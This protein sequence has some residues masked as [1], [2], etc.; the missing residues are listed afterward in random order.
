MA[1][2]TEVVAVRYVNVAAGVPISVPYPLY[3]AL[4]VRVVY[5]IEA[6]VA[7]YN[8]DYTIS[9]GDDFDTFTLTPT[10]ALISKI[11][12]LMLANPD[13]VNY[14]T[15]RRRL[16]YLTDAT[17]AAVRY[18]PFTAREFDR[19]ALRF[20]QIQEQL[21]RA[22]T[23]KQNFVGSVAV[24]LPAPSA[25]RSL[26]WNA[27]EDGIENGP[28]AD[29]I[30]NAQA[31]A[32]LAASYAN[33]SVQG[34]T[35]NRFGV[36]SG[37]SAVN[38]PAGVTTFS[39]PGYYADGDTGAWPEIREVVEDGSPLQPWQVR[40]N[41]GTRRWELRSD[42][43][44]PEMMGARGNDSANDTSA[45]QAAADYAALKG[46][47]F[48]LRRKSVYQINKL[49][50]SSNTKLAGS[51]TIKRR[52]AA[53]DDYTVKAADVFNVHVSGIRID[54]NLAAQTVAYNNLVFIGCSNYSAKKCDISGAKKIGGYGSGIAVVGGLND[55]DGEQ[56]LIADNK[57]SGNQ[58]SGIYVSREYNISVERNLCRDNGVDGIQFANLVYPPVS[59]VFQALNVSGNRCR[60]NDENGINFIGFYR[61]FAITGVDLGYGVPPARFVSITGNHCIDNE[62]YGLIW[63]GAGG[64]VSG[65]TIK[66]NGRADGYGGGLLCNC[67]MSVIA[68]N[69]LHDNAN[70][71][72]DA[73]GAYAIQIV[74]NNLNRGGV[75]L[76]VQTI[77]IGC[78]GTRHC[79]V[80]GNVIYQEGTHTMVGIKAIGTEATE[81]SNPINQFGIGITISN[82]RIVSNGATFSIGMHVTEGFERAK[83]ENNHVDGAPSG[84]SYF[85]EVE[86]L[87]ESN[88]TSSET[89]NS[90]GEPVAVVPSGN[91]VI[92]PDVGDTFYVSGT[93]NFDV[94][95]TVAA[96]SYHQKVRKVYMA[97]Q[98]SGY[99]YSSPPSVVFSGGGGSGAAGWAQIDTSGRIVDVVMTNLGSGYT[100]APSVSFVG[101][102]GSGA[103]AAARIG[104]NNFAG[105]KLSLM[106]Q[107]SL[108]VANTGNLGLSASHAMTGNSSLRLRGAYGN[109]YQESFRVA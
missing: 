50:L 2:S 78:G 94:I 38:V 9:L 19:T 4:D 72:I 5:G 65:N 37:L 101:G 63:Q 48:Y 104:C 71:Q 92:I 88:N 10:A 82:N 64:H 32:Q 43:V 25:G 7:V 23:L 44:T 102:S 47:L 67:E 83:I 3:E 31:Y 84:R 66:G 52:A 16:G 14:V 22:L 54:G 15:V 26:V 61:S 106:F 51:G 87:I 77:D 80:D 35:G 95:R 56:S 49:D 55:F 93:A 98:G 70:F 62:L 41:G 17:A 108:T 96:N 68:H 1:V 45:T 99:S 24:E 29:D 21:N 89:Y 11:R 109:W 74:G 105:K 30:A 53:P 42:I 107:S 91:P 59:D 85:L 75:T 76:G 69:I 90:S 97:S 12:A 28:S 79:I 103:T 39:T 36:V 20:Q 58:G 33:A 13:E 100:S 86:N 73:G 46:V 60:D 34:G 57:I 40:T 6:L 81:P 8:T 18:T 27:D